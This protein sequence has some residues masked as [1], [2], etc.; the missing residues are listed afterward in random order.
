MTYSHKK[1]GKHLQC[2]EFF[3]SF[4]NLSCITISIN[5]VFL[6]GRPS[7]SNKCRFSCEQVPKGWEK[8]FVSITSKDNGKT[9]AKSGKALVR[10]GSCEWPDIF[11]QSIMVSRDNSSKKTEDSV[12]KLL[13]ATVLGFLHYCCWCY[14]YVLILRC[15]INYISGII[16]IWHPWRGYN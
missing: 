6:K 13:V 7:L 15:L 2:P 9:T 8:L 16:K 12:F 3:F 5:Y 10:N 11:S 14:H 1:Y 4:F